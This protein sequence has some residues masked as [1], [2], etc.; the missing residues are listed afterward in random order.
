MTLLKDMS[1]HIFYTLF[2]YYLFLH[3]TDCVV[4]VYSIQDYLYSAFY[5]TIIAKQLHRKLYTF[6]HRISKNDI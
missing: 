2:N 3:P 5:D 6:Y 1:T 4:I